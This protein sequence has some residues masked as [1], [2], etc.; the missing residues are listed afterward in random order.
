MAGLLLYAACRRAWRSSLTDGIFKGVKRLCLIMLA[1]L[2]GILCS[3]VCIAESIS[4][5]FTGYPPSVRA[6]GMGG[7]YSAIA[8][9]ADGVLYNPA[10]LGFDRDVEF[11]TIRRALPMERSI[12]T[13]SSRFHVR[14]GS[15]GGFSYQKHAVENLEIRD[16]AGVITG[17]FDDRH[18]V[19]SLSQGFPIGPKMAFGVTGYL[20]RQEILEAN[21]T[22]RGFHAGL[23]LR[24]DDVSVGLVARHIGHQRQWRNTATD[25]KEEM[26]LE[27]VA[28]L[29][30]ERKRH[31]FSFDFA[32]NED[33]QRR[34]RGGVESRVTE[35]VSLRAGLED[36]RVA[37]GF[38][39]Q[40][41]N[42]RLDG[43]SSTTEFS[44][45]WSAGLTFFL[46]ESARPLPPVVKNSSAP[47]PEYAPPA[48]PPVVIQREEEPVS[49][50]PGVALRRA[51]RSYI[52]RDW[53]GTVNA[54]AGYLLE[55][56]QDADGHY[57]MGLALLRL[58][59]RQ[60]AKLF[61]QKGMEL[62]PDSPYA[63]YAA[64][65]SE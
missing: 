4:G 42:F 7:A 33:G 59:Q 27:Y 20:E 52:N 1:V 11:S 63:K 37:W 17:H 46:P 2:L 31:T 5:D 26:P 49:L 9:G 14:G 30:L 64:V 24:D 25:P 58:D 65:L 41:K 8:H 53:I 12:E 3:G 51:R 44:Q 32:Q 35:H 16:N 60:E 29:A 10:G 23:I 6:E 62:A 56:G 47:E 54:L 36:G 50:A 15:Y 39:L 38:G 28:G 18:E 55:H 40:G 57:L 19:F 61:L 13:A 21:A 43:A 48:A 34:F 22:G 45:S